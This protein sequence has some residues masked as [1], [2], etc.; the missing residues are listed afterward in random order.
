M[1]Q[2]CSENSKGNTV[3]YEN[4]FKKEE[5]RNS[6]TILYCIERCPLSDGKK[7]DNT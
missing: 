6:F 5:E 7:L 1:N 2:L 4:K 3:E